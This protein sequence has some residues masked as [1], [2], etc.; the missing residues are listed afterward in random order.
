MFLQELYLSVLKYTFLHRPTPEILIHRIPLA[1]N[2]QT[3]YL[4]LP[5]T[6]YCCTEQN[7]TLHRF[8]EPRAIEFAIPVQSIR[9]SKD[10]EIFPSVGIIMCVRYLTHLDVRPRESK[11]R[12][13]LNK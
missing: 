5:E 2:V 4:C 6:D 8:D 3:T 11:P 10:D 9:D 13:I 1:Y 12:P 7:F